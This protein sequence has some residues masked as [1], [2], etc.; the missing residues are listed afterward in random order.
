MNDDLKYNNTP[1]AELEKLSQE[2][3]EQNKLETAEL[4]EKSETEIS[5]VV[6]PEEKHE[7]EISEVTESEE[8]LAEEQKRIDNTAD[9][10][11]SSDKEPEAVPEIVQPDSEP[12]LNKESYQSTAAPKAIE[13]NSF[14]YSP[15]N[16]EPPNTGTNRP[17]RTNTLRNKNAGVQNGY[18]YPQNTNPNNPHQ[19]VNT[20][21]NRNSYPQNNYSSVSNR[22]GYRTPPNTGSNNQHPKT[23]TV[24]NKNTYPQNNYNTGYYNYYQ[25]RY[26]Y[27][28]TP[29]S[30]QASYPRGQAQGYAPYYYNPSPKELE[31]LALSKDTSIAGAATITVLIVMYIVAIIIEVIA[32]FCGVTHDVPD[33]STDPYIGFTPMGFYLYEGLSSLLSMFIPGLIII[34]ISK[35]KIT[36]LMPFKRIEGKKLFAIVMCGMSVCMIAQLMGGL[37]GINFGL[38]GVDLYD[39]LETATAT[40]FW[41]VIM[42]SICTALIPA[43]VEEFVYRGLVT[44]LLKEHD[45]TLAIVGSAFLFGMAHG[46][47]GQIP[48]AFV[49]GLVLA[50]VRVKTD[51]MLPGILI[52]FG[53]NF[54]AVIIN[55]LS[56]VLPQPYGNILDAAVI[57]VLIVIGFISTNYLAKNHKDLFKLEKKQSYLT[58]KEKL[59]V[60]FKTGTVIACTVLLTIMSFV[61]LLFV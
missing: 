28:Q 30:P 23:N 40:G 25:N 11:V 43:L 10:S 2:L 16:Q 18:P 33:T 32:V 46:N 52:H 1:G 5:E 61:I 51:S 6:E 17:P 31:K 37:I 13:N 53:N 50:Y 4:E 41:D 56:E 8:K 12:V 24:R 3:E 57:L 49:V 22:N 44:G 47:F 39:G 9:N 60:F 34:K 54:Y 45:D 20:V 19:R 26:Q 55:T 29:Q 7:T 48:F 21:R 59:K 27:P 15:P 36:N 58:Y 14:S 42:N 35:K 38:F